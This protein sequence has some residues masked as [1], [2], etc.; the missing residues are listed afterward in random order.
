M[1][2]I[3]SVQWPFWPGFCQLL[4]TVSTVR[5]VFPV[6]LHDVEMTAVCFVLRD[7]VANSMLSKF[8][9]SRTK[10]AFIHRVECALDVKASNFRS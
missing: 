8:V 6:I 10:A 9:C 1:C 4:P 7:R 3:L 5:G 2:R